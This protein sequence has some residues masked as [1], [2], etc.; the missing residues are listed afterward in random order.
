ML[1]DDA[2]ELDEGGVKGIN[3]AFCEVFK[4]AAEGDEVVGLG[5]G[6]EIFAV[7]VFFAI[8]LEAVFAEEFLGNVGGAEFVVFAGDFAGNSEEATEVAF[9]VFGGFARAAAFDFEMFDEVVDKFG[10]VGLGGRHK[11]IVAY[12]AEN[13]WVATL[14]FMRS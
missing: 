6:L 5:D 9:V 3:T 1:A 8:E 12:W 14:T 11:Y 10:D 7:A 2:G 13:G 4:E